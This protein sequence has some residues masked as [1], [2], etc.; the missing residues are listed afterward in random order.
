MRCIFSDLLCSDSKTDFNYDIL[1][2]VN[3]F[4]FCIFLPFHTCK[5]FH[6][7]LDL[8]RQDGLLSGLIK[9]KIHPVLNLP[10]DDAEEKA[11]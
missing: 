11:K 5:L 8:P 6:L 2:T 1:I 4:I 9:S 7:A 3:K 10:T